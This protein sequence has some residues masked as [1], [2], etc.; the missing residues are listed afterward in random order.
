MT[1]HARSCLV[2]VALLAV[3]CLS[4]A[5][6]PGAPVLQNAWANPGITAAANVGSGR[7]SRV[8]A[9]AAAWA[10]GSGR[11][12]VSGGIGMRDAEVGGRGVAIGARAAV[13]VVSFAGGAL[14]VAGFA[15]IGSAREPDALVD[16]LGDK[17]GTFT[18][19][20]IGAAVGYRRAFGFIRG[21][22]VYGAPFYSY[23][24]LV[25]G[26]S[27]V[28]SGAFRFSLGA[29]VGITSRIGVS[30]GA[31]MGAAAK[32]GKPGPPGTVWGLGA[33]YALGRRD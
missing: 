19:V 22:S 2:T 10:P 17:G 27:S 29:D 6:L 25:V 20:P 7:G 21:L 12:Q 11:F 9:L 13:P 32:V 24:R 14:G 23:N 16:P 5:Q 8:A 28:S 3:P 15:G 4:G 26:D 33:S 31:E 18:Q 1:A 30:V